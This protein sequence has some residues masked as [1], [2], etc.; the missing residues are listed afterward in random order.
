MI[1][2]NH[3]TLSTIEQQFCCCYA[4]QVSDFVWCF[5]NNYVE[6]FGDDKSGDFLKIFENGKISSIFP[7]IRIDDKEI[8]FLPKPFLGKQINESNDDGNEELIAKK[9]L[10]KIR[11]LSFEAMSHLSK[12]IL[13]DGDE[14]F[15]NVDF[16][17]EFTIIGNEF[18]ILP[19]ELDLELK[20]LLSKINF[21]QQNSTIRVNV[22]RFGDDSIPFDQEEMSFSFFELKN[23]G[24]ISKIRA[25]LYFFEEM[26]DD[27]NFE[28]VKNLLCDN[29]IGGKR[30]LGKGNFEAIETI[31]SD[32][33]QLKNPE[34]FLLLSG[35]I[36]QKEELPFIK[37]YETAIDDGFIT[38]GSATSLK[39]DRVFYI[40]EGAILDKKV[41][42]K[43]TEQD[44]VSGKLYRYGKAFL[45]P[46]GGGK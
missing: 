26:I 29:G 15:H 44:F 3:K 21:Y 13:K 8:F 42:G 39:K 20:D 25:F 32:F 16:N 11:W 23:N 17:Q 27:I 24:E 19:S 34:C 14:F 35:M 2:E 40:K 38:Y 33:F 41:V 46:L 30:N 31:E 6:L 10:K 12:S 18:L 4:D 22:A 7:A 28:A 9:K 45:L 1:Y 36:P 5:G 37:T 43:I